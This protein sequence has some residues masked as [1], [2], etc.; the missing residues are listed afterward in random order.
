MDIITQWIEENLGLA[1]TFQ[2]QIFYSL[3]V[4]VIVWATRLILLSIIR[5]REEDVSYKYRW[6]KTVEYTTLF[7]GLLFIGR[8]W[9]NDIGSFATYLG[10]LSAG[11]AIALQDPI[12]NFFGWIFII[13]RHPFDVGDRIE[14]GQNAGDVV[15]VRYFQFTIMEIGN[16]VDADQ[17]TGRV[18][19]I[20]NRKIF[21]ETLANYS[22]GF[23]YIWNEIPV[24]ITFESNRQKTKEILT[25][26][27][28]KHATP[29]VNDA[30]N[31]VRD[32]ARHYMIFYKNL[33]PIVYTSVEAS[34]ILLTMR[35]LC[36]P[37]QRRGSAHKIW[38][39]I[40]TAFDENEDI[41]FA[42]PTQRIYFSPQE[43]HTNNPTEPKENK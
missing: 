17:S 19:H 18:L 41:A 16:W 43:Q 12:T 23:N 6:R 34:G 31:S 20:P 29:M 14:I 8:I 35:Y 26:I 42:Y 22:R 9:V 33:T 28:G 32:A 40:L 27:I 15:D 5:R 10:L 25:A 7:V 11:L 4:I 30:R 38:E 2:E 21:N 1:P 3:I 37:R 24:L 39:D 36:D 13:F